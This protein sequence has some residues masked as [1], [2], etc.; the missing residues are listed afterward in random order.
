MK[1]DPDKAKITIGAEDFQKF[2]EFFYRKTGIHF[3]ASKRYFVD[4]RLVERVEAT[5]SDSFRDY[6]SMLRFQASGEELQTLTNLMTV[7]ETYF[8]REEYQFKCLVDSLLSE[9]VARKT[10]RHPIRIWVIPSSS[11]EEPYSI[12]IYLLERWPGIHAWD[13]EIIASDIDTRILAQARQGL[14]SARSIQHLPDR[15]L[16]HYFTRQSDG[17]QICRD[18]RQSVTFTRVNLT[19]RAD[20]RGYRDFDVIFC[21]NLL[22]YFDDVSRKTA[23]ETFYDALRPGGFVCLGHSESMSRSSSLYKVRKFP[24]AI[25]YQRPVETA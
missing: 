1:T 4:K 8:F 16:Q 12:A 25:V 2:R 18:L 24:E 23:T 6:F 7:N 3:D 22:I 10:D 11:G 15:Y 5:S 19:E 9:I 17:Y 13:V 20:T 21:R 14:Y